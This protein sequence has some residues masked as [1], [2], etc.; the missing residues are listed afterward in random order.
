MSAIKSKNLK[1]DNIK[2]SKKADVLSIT[3]HTALIFRGV[4]N[5]AKS[6]H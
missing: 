6:D 2:R 3:L 5:G 1:C 4:C